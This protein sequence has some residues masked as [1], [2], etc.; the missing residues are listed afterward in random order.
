LIVS[1]VIFLAYRHR[2]AEERDQTAA[3]Q[4]E[5]GNKQR[6]TVCVHIP[7]LGGLACAPNATPADDSEYYA[8]YDLRAQQE[9]AD[10]ALL[11]ALA[12]MFGVGATVIGVAYVA[13][14]LH[15]T[16]KMTGEAAKATAAADRAAKAA[17]D[18]NVAFAAHSQRELRA[19]VNIARARIRYDGIKNRW[20]S[21]IEFQNFGQTPASNVSIIGVLEVVEWPLDEAR[22]KSIGEPKEDASRYALG[23]GAGRPKIDDELY[24]P[25]GLPLAYAD[26]AAGC[27]SAVAKQALVA[28]G[29]AVYRDVFDEP[30]VTYYRYF[31]G[32][33]EGLRDKQELED[34]VHGSHDYRM[35]AH[36]DGND[37]T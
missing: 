7:T 20:E 37:A 14:T 25:N 15:E 22:L 8:A 36:H 12:S 23:P 6:P 21:R 3:Y 2:H 5:Q 1:V 24:N 31:V 33:H 35:V 27:Y 9:M 18:S 19:Y 4:Q 13:L 11:M 34:G 16:R 17:S 10:W 28:H 32:G 30:R 29:K 26:V